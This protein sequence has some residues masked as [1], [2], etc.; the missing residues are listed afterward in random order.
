MMRTLAKI[1]IACL[2]GSSP[3]AAET[4]KVSG[5]GEQ[6]TA[7]GITFSMTVNANETPSGVKGSIQYSR[8]E[9][10]GVQALSVHAQAACVWV[11]PDGTRAVV[12]GPAKVQAGAKENE[13]FFAAIKE[14]GAGSGDRVR[15]GFASESAAMIKCD[16]GE[17]RFPG[18]VEEGN[19]TI[20]N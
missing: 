10:G 1:T 17:T 8:T 2:I 4:S 14:G 9:N 7:G 11:S 5:G 19:F 16:A 15:A 12:A 3:A 18:I 20:H 13:W 6:I